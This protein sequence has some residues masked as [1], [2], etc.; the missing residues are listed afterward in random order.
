MMDEKRKIKND[1]APGSSLDQCTYR[2]TGRK[3]P[4]YL[5][6]SASSAAR[7]T[8]FPA[9]HACATYIFHQP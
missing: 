6:T 2:L 9:N 7:V 3:T 1:L 8:C 4:T 5:L